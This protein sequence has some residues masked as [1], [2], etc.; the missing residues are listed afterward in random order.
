MDK[1][2]KDAEENFEKMLNLQEKEMQLLQ[3]V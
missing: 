3:S 1:L 2:K